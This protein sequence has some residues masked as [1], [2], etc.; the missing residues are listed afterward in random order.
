MIAFE[1][2]YIIDAWWIE[3][4]VYSGDNT[5]LQIN[6]KEEANVEKALLVFQ[7]IQLNG[8]ALQIGFG[9]LEDN[10]GEIEERKQNESE[11]KIISSDELKT[12]LVDG[13]GEL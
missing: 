9:T 5:Q 13:F 8:C 11:K 7:N 4:F 2:K 6:Y 3:C 10:K 12:K 1:K